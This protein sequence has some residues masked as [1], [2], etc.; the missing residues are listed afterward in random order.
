MRAY[1]ISDPE[2]EFFHS[3]LKN[4][5]QIYC[6]IN[7]STSV[8]KSISSGVPQGSILGPLLFLI[9]INDLPNAVENVEITVFADDTS[10]SK[11]KTLMSYAWNLSQHLPAFVN[12]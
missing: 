6:S 8:F 2:L 5:V 12:G 4:R 7:G 1:G 9:Y 11:F 3:H 10:L